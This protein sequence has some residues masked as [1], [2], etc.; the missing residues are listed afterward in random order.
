M[1]NNKKPFFTILGEIFFVLCLS[2]VSAF[3]LHVFVYPSNFAPSGVEGIA[4]MIQHKTGFNAGITSLI[5][6]IPLLIT[7]WFV[8]KKKYV[9]YT[10][11]FNLTSSALIIL[12]SEVD[13]YQY[14]DNAADGLVAAL[15]SGIILGVRTGLMLRLGASTGGVDIPAG[16]IQK[17]MPHLNTERI[18]SII[19]YITIVFSF[20]VYD[21]NVTSVLLS[22]VQMFIFD[23]FAGFMMKDRRNAVE[24]KIITKEPEKIKNDIMCNLKHGATVLEGRG[25]YTDGVSSV[26]ISVINIRQIP[27]FHDIMKN[28]PEAFA[29]YG[30]LMGVKGNFRWKRDDAVK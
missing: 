5:F 22:F 6:N 14:T 11:I 9:I 7:A 12:L 20:F 30:E 10:L 17:K 24:V 21:G 13:F 2:A 29:Y 25:M 26:I 18:I 28:H 4:T 19:C 15:F 1:T 27:E 16:M 3:C 8:L 23:K